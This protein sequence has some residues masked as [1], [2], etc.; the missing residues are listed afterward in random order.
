MTPSGSNALAAFGNSIGSSA[1]TVTLD[2]NQTLGGLTFSNTAGGSY[3]L[4]RSSGDSSSTL[5]LNG[6]GFGAPVTVTGGNHS[7]AAPVTLADNM[8]FNAAAGTGL[9]ISGSISGNYAVSVNGSGTL[10]LAGANTY[11]GITAITGG[12]LQLNNA[13][14]VQNSTVML[15]DAGGLAFG[16]GV[17][18]FNLGGLKGQGNGS[19]TLA[20]TAGNAVGISVGGNNA[21]TTYSAALI[22]GP[23]SSFTKVGSGSMLL[24]GSGINFV[25]N[26]TVSAGTLQVWDAITPSATGGGSGFSLGGTAANTINIAAGAMLQ[27]NVD[28]N[29]GWT[30]DTNDREGMGT[31]GGTTITGN[32]VFQKIGNATLSFTGPAFNGYTTFAMTGGT[33]DVENGWFRNGG[34]HSLYWTNNLASLNIGPNGYLDVLGRPADE[35]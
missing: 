15:A 17:G 14:A 35:C 16:T 26:V 12:T 4:S 11:S 23:G 2:G 25:G 34:N 21:S 6:G 9:T 10:V 27:M 13:A 31:G 19:F 5:T 1:A 7:I 24:S 20:D 3:T 29:T 30:Y 28:N 32:G 33:I 8:N 18:T 22:G